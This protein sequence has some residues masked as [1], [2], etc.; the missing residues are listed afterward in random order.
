MNAPA[1][2]QV[3]FLFLDFDS[4]LFSVM[5]VP[6]PSRL[7]GLWRRSFFHRVWTMRALG[8]WR[9]WIL[10]RDMEAERGVLELP[11][12]LRWCAGAMIPEAHWARLPGRLRWQLQSC[13]VGARAPLIRR[14]REWRCCSQIRRVL[15]SR[16][17]G[18]VDNQARWAIGLAI[19]PLSN[20]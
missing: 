2:T 18:L 13:W 5:C 17:L 15:C 3:H 11:R 6:V 12:S 10:L 14:P 8:S 7:L 1:V 4:D 20:S 9:S 19:G 16:C